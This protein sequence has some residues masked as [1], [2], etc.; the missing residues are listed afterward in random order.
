[1]TDVR[2]LGSQSGGAVGF[3]VLA[4]GVEIFACTSL[5]GTSLN[6]GV[7]VP[8]GARLRIDVIDSS[9]NLVT[10]FPGGPEEYWRA[11][12]TGYLR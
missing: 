12:I 1:M 10:G 8:P 7:P 3:K 4:D 9:G 2:V 5:F 6:S 11:S